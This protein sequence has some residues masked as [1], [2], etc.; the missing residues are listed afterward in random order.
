MNFI[1][2]TFFSTLQNAF[3]NQV[4]MLVEDAMLSLPSLF[5]SSLEG[6]CLGWF[7]LY[8]EEVLLDLSCC[9]GQDPL[10]GA[11]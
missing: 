5:G 11:F 9:L 1:F 10:E 7:N 8:T 6:A 2:K 3:W 4:V